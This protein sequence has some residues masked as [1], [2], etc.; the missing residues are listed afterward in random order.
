MVDIE[1]VRGGENGG[2]EVDEM[3]SQEKDVW[4]QEGKTKSK[5]KWH[6]NNYK[7]L[8]LMQYRLEKYDKTLFL[9]CSKT[10]K[11]MNWKYKLIFPW[12]KMN[13]V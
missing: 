1:D 9:W 7:S 8:L 5:E 12:Y 3:K 2:K 10:W 6:A 4:I 13:Y 11:K